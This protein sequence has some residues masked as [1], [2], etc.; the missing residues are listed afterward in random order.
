MLEISKRIAS[1]NAWILICEPGPG[2]LYEHL[3]LH[4]ANYSVIFLERY[5]FNRVYHWN[6]K[7][8]FVHVVTDKKILPEKN[9]GYCL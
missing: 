6:F 8:I 9:S 2:G 7:G 1:S 5:I 3:G 4:K